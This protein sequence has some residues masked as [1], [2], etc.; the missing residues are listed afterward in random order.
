MKSENWIYLSAFFFGVLVVNI[1]DN[2]A[3]INSSLLNRYYLASLSFR[4]IVYEEYFFWILALRMKTVIVLAIG[5]RL[6]SKKIM[7]YGFAI[8]MC[9]ILGSVT[10]MMILAN[11]IWGILFLL[12]GLMPQ[13]LFYMMAFFV[14][15][16][17]CVI[18]TGDKQKFIERIY[19]L[20]LVVLGCICEAMI[21]PII[22]ENI[23]KY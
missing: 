4:E 3:G 8:I 11:G 13:V 10:V 16:R 18:R 5:S 15:K 6:V 1:L 17:E 12:C 22:I 20:V 21:S 2:S 14:W 9:I 23:I 7:L 19:I